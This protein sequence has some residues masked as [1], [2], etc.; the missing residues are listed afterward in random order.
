MGSPRHAAAAG[1][2]AQQLSSP[3]HRCE[4]A[5]CWAP[6]WHRAFLSAPVDCGSPTPSTFSPC[7]S[8]HQ[9]W[10]GRQQLSTLQKQL[11]CATG[12]CMGRKKLVARA[13]GC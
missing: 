11:L 5:R 8:K 3:A 12:V 10:A 13:G 1:K 9:V 4:V 6:G 7:N 2:E